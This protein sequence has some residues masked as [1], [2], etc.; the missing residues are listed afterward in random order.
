MNKK[1][2]DEVIT[3]RDGLFK[4]LTEEQIKKLDICKYCVI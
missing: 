4:G 1:T 3:M 2:D